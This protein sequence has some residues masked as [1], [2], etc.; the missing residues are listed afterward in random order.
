[1]APIS[2]RPRKGSPRSGVNGRRRSSFSGSARRAAE[3][4]AALTLQK[5]QVDDFRQAT[6]VDG[7]HEVVEGTSSE[8]LTPELFVRGAAQHDHRHTGRQGL[9]GREQIED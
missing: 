2:C 6:K 7:L 4:R 8:G 1:M 9:K 3:E 5:R